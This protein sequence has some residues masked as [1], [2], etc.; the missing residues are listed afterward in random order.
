MP[1]TMLTGRRTRRTRDG[2]ACSTR[3]APAMPSHQGRAL[4]SK[5]GISSASVSISA[6]SMRSA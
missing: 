6:L 2:S 1:V 3:A 5:I 4:P